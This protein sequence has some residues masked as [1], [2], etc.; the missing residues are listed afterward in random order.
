MKIDE[1]DLQDD[2]RLLDE[3]AATNEASACEAQA[4]GLPEVAAFHRGL[5]AG[6]RNAARLIDSRIQSERG[7]A[8][9]Q[10]GGQE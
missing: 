10:M 9:A 6:L 8:P 4:K 1:F 2:R 3:S 7:G 5:A